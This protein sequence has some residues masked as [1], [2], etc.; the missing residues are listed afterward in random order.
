MMISSRRCIREREKLGLE[1]RAAASERTAAS[2]SWTNA[3]DVFSKSVRSLRG[4]GGPTTL[5]VAPRLEDA[6]R[7]IERA[8]E[9]STTSASSSHVA[10]GDWCEIELEGLV[11]NA[12]DSLR[13][14]ERDA[15][16]LV[17]QRTF[18]PA[19]I[20][21][22]IARGEW[23]VA[24]GVVRGFVARLHDAYVKAV[25]AVC[26]HE[27][28]TNAPAEAASI[29]DENVCSRFRDAKAAIADVSRRATRL[30]VRHDAEE[31]IYLAHGTLDVL[32]NARIDANDATGAAKYAL[33]LLRRV[34]FLHTGPHTTAFAR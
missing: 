34:L 13:R 24:V 10:N 23:D 16:G 26:S 12:R 32:C 19:F 18:N 27:E 17:T 28:T 30:R 33:L 5:V 21:A 2:A 31:A 7:A 25:D 3:D 8:I 22:D 9:K 14:F 11:A 20:V 29:R 15:R 4:A 6:L 1:G